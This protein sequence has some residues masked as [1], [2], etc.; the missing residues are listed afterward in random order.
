MDH[1]R[2]TSSL[3]GWGDK[4]ESGWGKARKQGD[5][6]FENMSSSLSTLAKRVT[7]KGPEI[8]FFSFFK[9]SIKNHV[10]K[11]RG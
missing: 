10:Y 11:G 5:L 7:A 9:G 6:K 3:Q 8:S 4:F 1:G 2:G